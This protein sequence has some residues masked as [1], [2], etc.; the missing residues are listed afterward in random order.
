V[1]RSDEGQDPVIAPPVE[2]EIPLA[3]AVSSDP[4]PDLMA[5]SPSG[6]RVF[7]TFRG[8]APLT[9]NVPGVNNA[10]GATPGVAVVRVEENGRRGT[11]QTLAPISNVVAGV[12]T[13]DPHAVAVRRK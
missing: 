10:V 13:A 12:E 1:T 11:L 4:T 9:G 6:N 8:P 5:I 3:G 2:R 7:I